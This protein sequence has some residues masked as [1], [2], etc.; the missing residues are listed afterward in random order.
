MPL[1]FQG[2]EYTSKFRPED[3]R[4]SR[5]E[6]AIACTGVLFFLPLISVPDSRFGRYWANQGLVILLTEIA[7]LI[8]WLIAGG[9]LQLLGLI[10]YVGIVFR[11]LR[12]VFGILLLLAVLFYMALPMS[13]A[14][15]GRAKDAPF[16][17]FLRFI[18]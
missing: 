9:V 16:F 14:V 10:P 4:A 18:R 11:I 3:A 17:G 7:A 2:K 12:I 8:A 15:R 6:A 5:T 13:F 1:S